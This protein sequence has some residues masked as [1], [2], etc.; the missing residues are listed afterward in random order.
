MAGL[1]T[2]LKDVRKKFGAKAAKTAA[3]GKKVAAKTSK[4]YNKAQKA[5]AKVQKSATAKKAKKLNK[6]RV[7]RGDKMLRDFLE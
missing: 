2:K 3:T 1:G 7:T 6:A 5:Y 4:G